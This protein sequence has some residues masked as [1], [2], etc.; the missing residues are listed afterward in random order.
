[1]YCSMMTCFH[2]I[3]NIQHQFWLV[4]IFVSFSF[5][6]LLS[7]ISAVWLVSDIFNHPFIALYG[8][9]FDFS[10]SFFFSPSVFLSLGFCLSL[11][12]SH[13]YMSCC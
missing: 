2:L 3:V 10:L 7:D 4:H 5:C 13:Y 11:L 9:Y 6:C 1:M 8:I 12:V